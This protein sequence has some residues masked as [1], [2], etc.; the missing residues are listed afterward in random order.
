MR[1]VCRILLFGMVLSL[2]ACGP[3]ADDAA[4][5]AG[6][7]AKLYYEGLLEGKY[8]EFVAGMDRH[9]DGAENYDTQLK[10]N[11]RMFVSRM[12]KAH[13]GIASLEVSR[14]S[15]CDSAHVANV[16]M[17]IHFADSTKEQIVVPMVER[18]NVWL[19]R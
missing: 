16:F 14:V 9:L 17:Q 8:D 6:R 7:T 19:M 15:Y 5:V 12:E 10:A 3:S 18:D 2:V 1:H 13:Q 4:E 11:A